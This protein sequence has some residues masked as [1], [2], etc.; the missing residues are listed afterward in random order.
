ML[1]SA[2]QLHF[3]QAFHLSIAAPSVQSATMSPRGVPA[4]PPPQFA[5]CVLDLIRLVQHALA[6]FGLG[7]VRVPPTSD[8]ASASTWRGAIE[9]ESAVRLDEGDGLRKFGFARSV[10]RVPR[11]ALT[12]AW[13]GDAVCDQTVDALA[14]FRVDIGEPLLRFNLDE[15]TLP[16][17]LLAGLLSLVISARGKLISLGCN[18]VSPCHFSPCTILMPLKSRSRKT[19]LRGAKSS[20]S[21]ARR[22]RRRTGCNL[23]RRTSRAHS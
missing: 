23:P 11:G 17:A 14:L 10:D 18:G 22:S 21:R 2:Q 5:E 13:L 19:R 15:S 4:P 16:P 7:V 3:R 6:L 9:G 1:S 8:A 20:S 12:R